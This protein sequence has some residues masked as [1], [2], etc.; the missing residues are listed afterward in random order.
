MK[1]SPFFFDP[2]APVKQAVAVNKAGVLGERAVRL[3]KMRSRVAWYGYKMV[4]VGD[5]GFYFIYKDDDSHRCPERGAY[6]IE[7]AE[8]F[9]RARENENR[10]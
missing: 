6:T 9:I 2:V 8:R 4:E 5:G 10:R 3:A 7:D 1:T